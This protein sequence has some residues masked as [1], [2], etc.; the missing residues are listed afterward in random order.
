MH[1]HHYSI[2]ILY[3]KRIHQASAIIVC[4]AYHHRNTLNRSAKTICSRYWKNNLII[5]IYNL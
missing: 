5:I 2:P 1:K 4:L 3:Y